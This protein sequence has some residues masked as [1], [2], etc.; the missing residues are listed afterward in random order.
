MKWLIFWLVILGGAIGIAF[1]V[2]ALFSYPASTVISFIGGFI[3][4]SIVTG[5][6][7]NAGLLD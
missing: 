1:G 3:W 4:G 5:V 2:T 6:A 7:I